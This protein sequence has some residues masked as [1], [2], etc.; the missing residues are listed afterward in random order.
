MDHGICEL[1]WLT[2]FM[3]E[4]RLKRNGPMKLYRDNKDAVDIEHNHVHH[5]EQSTLRSIRHFNDFIK[6]KLKE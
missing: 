4:L 6:E 5:E 2:F 1:M 3:E